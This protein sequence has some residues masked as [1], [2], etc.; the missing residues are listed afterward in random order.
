MRD[1]EDSRPLRPP[2]HVAVIM[3]GNGRWAKS[4]GLPRTAG[5]KK[6]VDAVRRTVEAAGE[7]G[8]GYL[9]IFS[10]SSENWRRPEE[11]VSDLMQLLRFYL[12]SEIAD[13]HRNGVRLRV[14][15]DR[16]RLSKD[17]VSLIENAENLTRDN[18]KLTLVVALSYGSRQEITLAARRLAEEVRAGTLDP[19]DITE[20][21]L[22]ERLFT[23]DIPDP[24][25]IVRTS[26]EKRI[27]NFLLW[28]AAYAE[29]VFVDTLWP[30][31]SKRDL[32][33]AI[34]EFHRRERRFGATTGTR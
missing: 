20:D 22:S 1:A 5:H 15:G 4:R 26:G 8:I 14:I 33:A 19:A 10:F 7:L 2:A 27:S 12:R 25:L 32:E 3:D 9:T 6:G 21:R 18:R 24:D 11:E 29:L 16:A 23:A 30:D 13:L 28:Q 34:E 17:I 31:F